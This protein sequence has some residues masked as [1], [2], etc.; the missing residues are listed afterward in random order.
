MNSSYPITVKTKYDNVDV[1]IRY[2]SFLEQK[3]NY[4]TR[5]L[6][7]LIDNKN[8][9]IIFNAIDE[10]FFSY[11]EKLRWIR[12][13]ITYWNNLY[14]PRYVKGHILS[15]YQTKYKKLQEQILEFLFKLKYNFSVLMLKEQNTKFQKHKEVDDNSVRTIA[16]LNRYIQTCCQ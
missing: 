3:I 10:K 11:I 13:C 4:D 15:L 7:N 14:I 9:D 16:Q 1:V 6:E 2:L 5:R 12:D 8:P